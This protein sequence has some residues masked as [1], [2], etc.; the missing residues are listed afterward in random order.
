MLFGIVYYHCLST[1]NIGI[2]FELCKQN[3]NIFCVTQVII[4]QDG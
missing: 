2:R 3:A 1:A 4:Y